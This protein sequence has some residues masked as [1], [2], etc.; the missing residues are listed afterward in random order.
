MNKFPIRK[1]INVLVKKFTEKPS[2]L[3]ITNVL[4]F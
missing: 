3:N 1:R 2:F 4:F